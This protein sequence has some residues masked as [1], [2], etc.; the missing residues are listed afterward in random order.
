MITVFKVHLHDHAYQR[1][2]R[3]VITGSENAAKIHPKF[4]LNRML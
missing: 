2:Q 4:S 1:E 3:I